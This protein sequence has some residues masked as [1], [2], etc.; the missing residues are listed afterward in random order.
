[1]RFAMMRCRRCLVRDTTLG[2]LILGSAP[3]SFVWCPGGEASE[4]LARRRVV[5]EFETGDGVG[6]VGDAVVFVDSW[7]I[8]GEARGDWRGNGGEEE[9]RVFGSSAGSMWA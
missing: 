2:R 4:G 7:G 1:M 9:S 8:S 3:L 5:R 6:E